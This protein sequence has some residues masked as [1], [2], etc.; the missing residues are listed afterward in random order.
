MTELIAINE[1]T[2]LINDFELI[3]YS[4]N[5]GV[6][7]ISHSRILNLIGVN[8]YSD[9]LHK[10]LSVLRPYLPLFFLKRKIKKGLLFKSGNF[11]LKGIA[12]D[13]LEILFR[14]LLSAR[15]RGN[16]PY[17]LSLLA[18]LA[19]VYFMNQDPP[20]VSKE[21]RNIAPQREDPLSSSLKA[22]Q[23]RD[24]F[25]DSDLQVVHSSYKL[26]VGG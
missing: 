18:G 6:T 7:V 25:G 21:K 19:S 3:Y 15:K 10:H 1:R 23:S 11:V 2:I 22:S 9:K 20:P 8:I 13:D 24:Q 17:R 5:N 4:L 14:G 16:L 26:S 12:C